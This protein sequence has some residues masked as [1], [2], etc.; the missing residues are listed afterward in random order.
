MLHQAVRES[1]ASFLAEYAESG[2]QPRYVVR[3]FVGYLECGVLA[4]R[5]RAGT[6]QGLWRRA[7][8]GLLMREA[9]RLPFLQRAPGP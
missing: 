6:R 4:L 1:L 8:T 5:F 9:R 2:G 7:V 3:D